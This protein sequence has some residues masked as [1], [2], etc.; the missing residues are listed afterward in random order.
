MLFT[1]QTG[2]AA[3]AAVAAAAVAAVAAAAVLSLGLGLGLAASHAAEPATPAS[4]VV[5]ATDTTQPPAPAPVAPVARVI[6][7]DANVVSGLSVTAPKG[8]TVTLSAKGEKNRSRKIVAATKPAVFTGLTAGKTYTVAVD[9]KPVGTGTPV[10]APGAA[11]NLTV[12]STGDPTSALVTWK[13]QSPTY[14]AGVIEYEVRATPVAGQL[15]TTRSAGSPITVTTKTTVAVLTGLDPDLLYT[16][17]V[18][19]FNT[20]TTGTASSATLFTTLGAAAGNLT[21]SE[22]AEAAKKAEAARLAAAQA[23]AN[24][25]PATPSGPSGPTTKT[26]YVCPATFN[27]AAGGLC[28]K[29]M[30]YTYSPVTVTTP[31][32]THGEGRIVECSG[33]DCPG[34]Q[35]INFGTDWSGTTCPNGGTMH[36]GQ[37]L[38]WTTS[39]KSI[40]VSVKDAIPAGYVDNGSAWAKTE[41]VKNAAPA[42]YND[43]GSTW[44]SIVAQEAKVVPA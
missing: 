27:E 22:Q 3:V 21:A 9:G 26:I 15:P 20:A 7:I 19:P 4:G 32:T 35:Y 28:E 17:T 8:A 31:Y 24:Q 34:S 1:Q 38:G 23:A 25:R 12:T 39:T 16:F 29:T 6:G 30:A 13:Y 18:I 44:I 41:Q 40:T 42:G 11:Y 10:K 2:L 5:L 37:C 14:A 33:G 43:N 36:D